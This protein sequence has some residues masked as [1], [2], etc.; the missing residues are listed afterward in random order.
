M[1]YN[2]NNP[3]FLTVSN[4]KTNNGQRDVRIILDIISNKFYTYD[5]DKNFLEIGHS[6]NMLT[7]EEVQQYVENYFDENNCCPEVIVEPI[8]MGATR[9]NAKTG[10]I[11]Y[12]YD[13]GE[14]WLVLK[15]GGNIHEIQSF[16]PKAN[17]N[18]TINDLRNYTHPCEF[19]PCN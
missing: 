2:P 9:H 12:E 19:F 4:S 11:T 3:R 7:I 14:I 13:N 18:I 15:C 6:D 8:I 1:Q 5:D 16:N 17:H 10:I